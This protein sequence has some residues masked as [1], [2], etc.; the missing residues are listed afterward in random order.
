M[1]KKSVAGAAFRCRKAYSRSRQVGMPR[2]RVARMLSRLAKYV[3][4]IGSKQKPPSS[5]ARIRA[6][7]TSGVSMKP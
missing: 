7:G 4:S 5:P 3:V 6:S 1:R 2:P